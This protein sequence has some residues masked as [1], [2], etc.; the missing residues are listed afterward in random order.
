VD[1]SP[2]MLKTYERILA[3]ESGFTLVGTATDGRQALT[4]VLTLQPELVLMD[5]HMP[6]M[7]GIE[8]TRA[9]KQSPR[10]PL[11]IIVSSDD[12]PAAQRLA[13]TAGADH[14]V[15]KNGDLLQ[16][17]R[18]VLQG[19]LDS[20]RKRDTSQEETGSLGRV[21]PPPGGQMRLE[22]IFHAN[23]T[24]PSDS[25]PPVAVR[26]DD[27][28]QEK[29]DAT[30]RQFARGTENESVMRFLT[31]C[32]MTVALVLPVAN[33]AELTNNPA[34][35]AIRAEP[36]Q[37]SFAVRWENDTFGGTDRFYTDG[38]SLSLAQ[39]GSSWLDPIADW[40]PWGSGRRTVG[41][42]AGQIM[43]TPA[44]TTRLIPDPHDRPYAGILSVGLSL[45][46]ERDNHYNGLKFITGVVGPW[47]LAD[48][49][50]KQVHRWVG[51]G[52]SQGWDYQ[53][54]NEPIFNLVYEH[55]RKYRLLGEPQG[56]AVEALPAGNI[57]LGN[58]LTQGQIGGQF[59]FG[60]NIPDDFGTTLMRGMVHLP[61]PRPSAEAAAPKWGVYF[62][63]GANANIVLRNITLDGNT[64]KDSPS[65]DKEWFV[66]AA[67]VGMA[68]ATRRFTVAFTYVF[69]GKE[70]EGQPDNSEFGAFTVSY[71]F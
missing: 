59:R 46:V 51:S 50:Q 35:A 11:I 40:L 34:A 60:Y 3:L 54:H 26:G 71:A 9:M 6:H 13:K 18:A 21:A 30:G 56:F 42:E 7:N 31:A 52:L 45:H 61:P 66:P 27:A 49:T 1:D 28:A 64:W 8:T 57:M 33:A 22:L 43:V 38:V 70:F 25:Q 48:E 15:S 16:E 65:V 41:Y 67:E 17:L 58:V 55:R 24:R 62:F 68:V 39:T 5:I 20:Q 2:Y 37:W 53:L 4:S 63:G 29:F 47:S 14:F 23:P 44:D 69:W 32:L 19:L 12:S 10:P 36:R